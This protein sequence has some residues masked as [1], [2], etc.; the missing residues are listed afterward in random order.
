MFSLKF[1]TLIF[2]YC[3]ILCMFFSEEFVSA[4]SMAFFVGVTRP[5]VKSGMFFVLGVSESLKGV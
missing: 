4:F 5:I 3:V 2:S 1:S